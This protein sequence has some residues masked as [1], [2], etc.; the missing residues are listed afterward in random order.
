MKN[1]WLKNHITEL[2]AMAI[3]LF[4]FIIFGLV[5]L[6]NIKADSSITI[7]VIE[8]LKGMDILIIGFYFGSSIGSKNKQVQLDKTTQNEN[9]QA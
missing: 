2:I 4:T 5:L 3:I 6:G 7:S 8:C 9:I 1:D